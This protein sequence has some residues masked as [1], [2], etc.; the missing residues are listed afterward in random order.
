MS[1]Q[2]QRS[3]ARA[4]SDVGLRTPAIL[5]KHHDQSSQMQVGLVTEELS[6][7][8]GS[9]GIGGAFHEL[10]LALARAGYRV[11]LLYL[12]INPEHQRDKAITDYYSDHGVSVVAPNIDQYTW[13][14]SCYVHR[15][16]A[17]FRYLA[18]LETAY[19]V[20]HFHDYKGIGFF[21][22]AAKQQ[23]LAFADTSLVVQAHG[24]TRWT[25]RANGHPFTHPDQLKI[26]FLERQSIARADILTSPSR[27]M[28]EWFRRE[29]WSVPPPERV[30]VLQNICTHVRDLI[31]PVATSKE[32]RQFNEIVFF[33]RHE[34]RK[35]VVQ[36]C[37]TLDLIRD[38]LRQ[39]AITVSFLGGVGKI[40]GADSSVYLAG[41]A[42][43]WS[44]PI[45]VLTDFDR[46]SAACYLAGNPAALVVVPSPEENSPYTVLEAAVL[47]KP[48]ITSDAGGAR[49]LL[50]DASVRRCTCPIHPQALASKLREVI[51]NGLEPAHAANSPRETERRW[52]DLHEQ[53]AGSHSAA[54]HR[55]TVRAHRSPGKVA[56][57]PAVHIHPKVMAAIT[58]FERPA[59]LYDAM[60]SLACQ[61]YPNVEL[62][63]VDD[64]SST[65][66]TLL[67][68]KRMQ[69]LMDK[70]QVRLI[71]QENRYLG[72]ARNRA[73]NDT[74]SDYVLFLD[75][76][77]VAFPNLIQTLV[78]AAQATGADV[79]TCPNLYMPESRRFESYPFPDLF[80]QKISYVPTGG[81][82]A[83]VPFENCFGAATALIRRTAFTSLG[84]YTEDHGVGH[85]DFEFYVRAL[86]AGLRVEVCPLPLYL[87]EVDR[88][89]MAS[90]TSRLRNASRVI[91]SIE[92][93]ACPDAWQDFISVTAGGRAQEDMTNFNE[94][95]RK[96]SP[97]AHLLQQIEG[98]LA[99]SPEYATRVSEYASAVGA[100]SFA[101]AMM[102]LATQRG[103]GKQADASE[104]ALLPM[105]PNVSANHPGP[106]GD[107]DQHLLAS[108]IDLSF[109]RIAASIGNFRLSV[110]RSSMRLVLRHVRYLRSLCEAP[111][112]H[113]HDLKSVLQDL[114]RIRMTAEVFE[115]AAAVIFRLAVTARE[116]ELA[117]S[118]L[119]RVLATEDQDYL[120]RHPDVA[121]AAAR[122]AFRSG[123]EHYER[124]GRKE[125]RPGFATL[126]ELQAVLGV[127]LDTEPPLA[128]LHH[129]VAGLNEAEAALSQPA[130]SATG[131]GAAE[132]GRALADAAGHETMILDMVS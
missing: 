24:P 75:D 61:S 85:E 47:G 58:H 104:Q 55:A 83:M 127:L 52:I 5:R 59:K 21:S 66:E 71:R 11:D 112:V 118:V 14:P 43:R 8:P 128:A 96:T 69:P 15:S 105:L 23:C 4:I 97:H 3:P 110:E 10:S 51:A 60:L 79:V 7:G 62:V 123:L 86:Q 103:K 40:N 92:L 101:W 12:P 20:I 73:V 46:I 54:A 100:R 82:L 99:G 116:V 78:T 34:E 41:R 80:R 48:L 124:A 68:L 126:I 53:L 74:A 72:A 70:L 2:S 90:S 77:D 129:V 120:G 108:L 114:R 87:Y 130:D 65:Q 19:N 27:F 9:G 32:P 122:G 117:L 88:P 95:N 67:A 109:G 44:F 18:S 89:S 113:P 6:F 42:C 98:T 38:E 16:Y 76:D 84:G 56:A 63:V 35:G 29:D 39:R 26:D 91:R 30:H 1:N 17:M 33:G 121:D 93:S 37:D 45:S 13:N 64:G 107:V 22:L 28:L 31:A 111:N 119:D 49:E 81:P 102:R 94:Y 36:F 25:L 132:V 131:I 50:D 125:G 115:H 57:N 106:A